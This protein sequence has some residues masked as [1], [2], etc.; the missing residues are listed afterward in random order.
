MPL[1]AQSRDA[2]DATEGEDVFGCIV[3]AVMEECPVGEQSDLGG[4]VQPH[5][6]CS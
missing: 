2:G 1:R 4:V 3:D 6:S 5:V